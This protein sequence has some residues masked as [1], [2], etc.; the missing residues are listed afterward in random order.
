MKNKR[1]YLLV[2]TLL[3]LV[4][5][6]ATA[7]YILSRGRQQDTQQDNANRT[8]RFDGQLVSKDLSMMETD[9]PGVFIVKLVSQE[10]V[11]VNIDAGESACDRDAIKLP[12][13]VVGDRVQVSATLSKDGILRVCNA[14]TY[15][16]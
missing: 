2:G 13:K 11:A 4:I 10:H 6:G 12:E 15:I 3:I 5:C 16:K 14:G 7:W 9:G 8:V 1:Q